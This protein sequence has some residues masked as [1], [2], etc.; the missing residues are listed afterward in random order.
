MEGIYLIENKKNN[1]KYVG[2][3]KNI[4]RRIKEHIN[5]SNNPNR[6][7]YN[8]E[9]YSEMRE[10]GVESFEFSILEL[11]DN[12]TER[13]SYYY[14]ILNPEYNK[15]HPTEFPLQNEIIKNDYLKR[16]MKSITSNLD[17]GRT[18][19]KIIATE[20][21]TGDEFQ[22][23]SLM[24]AEREL[25]IHRSSISQILNCNHSRTKSKGYTFR[26]SN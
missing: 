20:I 19:I 17:K 14:E 23:N 5:W 24:E 10:Y 7:E 22:F 15:L 3:S 16:N 12:L 2:K 13:E 11:T 26:K 1:K 8:Y 25:G 21:S 18:K 4:K 6:K 9:L